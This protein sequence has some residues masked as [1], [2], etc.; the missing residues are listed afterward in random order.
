[1]L[2]YQLAYVIV[3][4]PYSDGN[5]KYRA[6]KHCECKHAFIDTNLQGHTSLMLAIYKKFDFSDLS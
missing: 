6:K 3:C 4:L 5:H 2:D 1:M